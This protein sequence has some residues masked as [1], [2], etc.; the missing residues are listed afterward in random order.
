MILRSELTKRLTIAAVA[1]TLSVSSTRVLEWIHSGEIVAINL[2]R[3]S[4]PDWRVHPRD[5]EVFERGR[6][7]SEV[8]H[9]K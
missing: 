5:L 6:S 7:T 9:A 3:S 1:E 2:S 4:R 8:P